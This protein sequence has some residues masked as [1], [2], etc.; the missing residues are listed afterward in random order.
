MNTQDKIA[1]LFALVYL[2]LIFGT[3]LFLA[4][5]GIVKYF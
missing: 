4:F 1:N 2:L 3:V 5:M